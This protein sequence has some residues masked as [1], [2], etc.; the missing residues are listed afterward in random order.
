[1]GEKDH[2]Y[3]SYDLCDAMKSYGFASNETL[4]FKY[5]KNRFYRI[6][7]RRIWTTTIF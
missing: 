6:E 1:M 3:K 2:F 7:D 5:K 4:N